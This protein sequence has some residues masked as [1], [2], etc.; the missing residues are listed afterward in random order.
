ML[1]VKVWL[2]LFISQDMFVKRLL[3][4]YKR[5]F[6]TEVNAVLPANEQLAGFDIMDPTVFFGVLIGAAIPAVFSAMLILGVD[7]KDVYKR[8]A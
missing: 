3:D 2:R 8:Q 7:K 6:I 4:V 5:Q 1:I